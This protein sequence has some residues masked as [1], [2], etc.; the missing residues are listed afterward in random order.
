MATVAS[1][2]VKL[3]IDSKRFDEGVKRAAR[4]LDN[5]ISRFDCV[6][7]VG[8]MTAI[9]TAVGA[10]TSLTAAAGPASGAI[11]CVACNKT[12]RAGGSARRRHGR[13]HHLPHERRPARRRPRQ[14]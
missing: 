6:G 10:L 8:K 2:L 7:D 12:A 3:G 14:V 9:T 1:L 13:A 5:L 4:G 11:L